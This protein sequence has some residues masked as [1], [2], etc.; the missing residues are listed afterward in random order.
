MRHKPI[1]AWLGFFDMSQG[2]VGHFQ[3][4]PDRNAR[5]NFGFGAMHTIHQTSFYMLNGFS[6]FVVATFS[7]ECNIKTAI[8]YDTNQAGIKGHLLCTCV[9]ATKIQAILRRPNVA[10]PKY[11]L[12]KKTIQSSASLFAYGLDWLTELSI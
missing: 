11:A 3:L 6:H 5:I 9:R 10:L 2:E 12:Q 8:F 1:F 7:I 4:R